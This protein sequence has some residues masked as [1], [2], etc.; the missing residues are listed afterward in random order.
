M[1]S[2]CGI[3][4]LSNKTSLLNWK[5]QY[6]NDKECIKRI[7]NYLTQYKFGMEINRSENTIAIHL[8]QLREDL[9]KFI[10]PQMY[11]FVDN[12]ELLN[13]LENNIRSDGTVVA[14]T[15]ENITSD[16]ICKS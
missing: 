1:K 10:V 11:Y 16:M 3:M 2:V 9:E 14:H 15:Y 4:H 12:S 13:Y 6:R 8:G 7:G 5:K